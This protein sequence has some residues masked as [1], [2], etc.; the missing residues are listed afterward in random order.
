MRSTHPLPKLVFAPLAWLKLQYFCHQG[1][2]EVGGFAVT[3]PENPFYIEE[4][5]TVRQDTSP[6]TVTFRDDAVADY[7]DKCVD[8]KLP[9]ERFARIWLHTHPGASVQPSRT[10]E[11]TFD[12][13]FGA[14]DW[15]VMTILGRT[16]KT[17]ARLS[18]AGPLKVELEIVTTVA[19]SQWPAHYFEGP[20]LDGVMEQWAREYATN[21][22]AAPRVEGAF[23]SEQYCNSS[24]WPWLDDWEW[25]DDRDDL[26]SE[27]TGVPD[28]RLAILG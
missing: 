3:A 6:V 26:S 15:A 17:F 21:I 11:E 9:P 20:S 19:W 7:F 8:R 28:E 23:G 10:D 14:C 25:L 1:E 18:L 27:T 12:R 24:N 4:F 13:V 22:N 5:I 2:T 16:G